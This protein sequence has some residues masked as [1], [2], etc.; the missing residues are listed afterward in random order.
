MRLSRQ[1]WPLR[2]PDKNLLKYA[3]MA[4]QIIATLG[5]AFFIG[6]KIDRK[7]GWRM[8]WLML[9]LP[10]LA[11]IGLFWNIYRDTKKKP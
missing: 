5:V 9:L 4:T 10:L 1:I 7:I 3:G 11:L 8:P 6:Y 2:M